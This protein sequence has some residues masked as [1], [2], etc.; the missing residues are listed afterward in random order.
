[1][2]LIKAKY[3]EKLLIIAQIWE[4]GAWGDGEYEGH[5]KNDTWHQTLG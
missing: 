5:V 4:K 1:V 3:R 2:G